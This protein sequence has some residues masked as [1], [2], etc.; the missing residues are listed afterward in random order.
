M[1]FHPPIIQRL[2]LCFKGAGARLAADTLQFEHKYTSGVIAWAL[3]FR[4]A[5]PGSAIGPFHWHSRDGL[6]I[7]VYNAIHERDSF[8]GQRA[9]AVRGRLHG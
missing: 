2:T 6:R 4:K 5:Q 8:H 3:S 9:W 7:R 1:Y